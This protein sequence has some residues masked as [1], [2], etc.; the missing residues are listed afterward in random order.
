MIRPVRFYPN[1]ETAA[2]NAFQGTADRDPEALTLLARKEFDTA[3]QMLRAAGVNVHVFEDTAEPEKPDA[4]FPNNWI[5]THHDGRIALFPMYSALRRRERRR[6]IVEELRKHYRVTEVIDYSAFEDEHCCLEGTGSLVLDHLN[7]V[8]YISLSNRSNPKVIQRFADDFKYDPVTFTSIGS[9]GQPIYHT[10]VMMCIGTRF[11]MLGLQMIPNKAERQQ[12][13]EQLEN[14]GR[15]I[16]E[17]TADQIANFAGNAIELHN[18]NREEL[19][20]LSSR[21]AQ[22][23]AEEQR[24]RLSRYARFVPLELPTIELGGGSARCMLATIHLP[25]L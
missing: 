23:L 24:E 20:V 16:V 17:L 10:N 15:E 18:K 2:D 4:V 12:V 14:S 21:A 11:A 5:S 9:D 8:A 22:A 3:V 25:R 6:D 7:K 1:P 13:R 19:L